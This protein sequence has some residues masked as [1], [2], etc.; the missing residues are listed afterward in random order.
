MVSASAAGLSVRMRLIRGKRMATPDLWRVERAMPSKAISSTSPG[1][2][3]AHRPE[4]VGG[5]VAHPFVE[6]A[7]LLVGEAEI[8]LADRRQLA[9]AVAASRQQPKVKSE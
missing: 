4:A 8:G 3:L 1:V 5:V 9:L 7:Q 2:D 6:P